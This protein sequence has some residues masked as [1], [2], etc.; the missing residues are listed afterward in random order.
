MQDGPLNYSISSGTREGTQIIKLV[1][2]LTLSTLFDLQAE[3]RTITSPLAILDL[4]ETQY[5]DSAGLGVLVNFYISC[6]K[7][8]RKMALAG[9]NYRIEALLDMTHIKS[10]FR[11]FPTVAAAEAGA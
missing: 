11:V 1:G 5:M 8:H 4:T 10:L 7:N 9:V 6:E 2:P 3:L